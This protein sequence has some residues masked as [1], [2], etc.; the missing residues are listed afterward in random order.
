MENTT[1][2]QVLNW[3]LHNIIQILLLLSTFIEITPRIKWNPWTSLVKW[4]GKLINGDLVKKIDSINQKVEKLQNDRY[5]D[6]KDRIRWEILDFA[7]SCR[8][9]RN[10]T[11]D[12]Y[13]HIITLNT[14]YKQLLHLTQDENGVF[15]EEYKYIQKLYGERLIK[16][17]F[18]SY[19]ED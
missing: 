8:N 10:H 19:K 1:L 6:E 18:L 15:E 13:D 4:I 12:E 5:E 11:K 2:E 16:N 14:K 9:G 7:N 3:L 17:D